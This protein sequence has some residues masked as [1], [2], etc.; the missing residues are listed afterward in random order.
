MCLVRDETEH[1]RLRR[2]R[3]ACI[4]VFGRDVI[5]VAR[6]IVAV[7][8]AQRLAEVRPCRV[9]ELELDLRVG[10]PRCGRPLLRIDPQLSDLSREATG[11]RADGRAPNEQRAV[12]RRRG[13]RRPRP[14][15]PTVDEDPC[16]PRSECRDDVLPATKRHRLAR[17]DAR[18][19]ADIELPARR[20]GDVGDPKLVCADLVCDNADR[21]GPQPRLDR[22]RRQRR[23]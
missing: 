8:H 11:G 2:R 13:A 19:A 5:V 16:A 21:I 22:C 18:R 14:D 1:R 6:H 15:G 12:R 9:R 23:G 10:H 17:H 7:E 4:L 20:A 3:R